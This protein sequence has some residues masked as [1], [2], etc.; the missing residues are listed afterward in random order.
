MTRAALAA[1]LL[2]ALVPGCVQAGCYEDPQVEAA[3]WEGT[4]GMGVTWEELGEASPSF[5]RIEDLLDQAAIQGGANGTVPLDEF[6]AFEAALDQAWEESGRPGGRPSQ[7]IVRYQAKE[8]T[9]TGE[10]V[11]L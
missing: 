11:C 4:P 8:W 7:N 5:P 1:A 10:G 9:V 2:G 6:Q 3:P